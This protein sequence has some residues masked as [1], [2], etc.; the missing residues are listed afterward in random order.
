[1][2]AVMVSEFAI[3]LRYG[4]EALRGAPAHFALLLAA[5]TGVLLGAVLF[6]RSSKPAEP[7]NDVLDAIAT[8][9]EMA[10]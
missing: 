8:R 3:P 6:R 1:M 9:S 7:G 4:R 5:A 10:R 2:T